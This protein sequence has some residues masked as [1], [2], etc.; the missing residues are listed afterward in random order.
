[1]CAVCSPNF[2][3]GCRKMYNVVFTPFLRLGVIGCLN[4]KSISVSIQAL[5]GAKK[6]VVVP[7]HNLTFFTRYYIF[8]A[9]TFFN[10]LRENL[11]AIQIRAQFMRQFWEFIHQLENA[12]YFFILFYRF[13]NSL[14]QLKLYLLLNMYFTKELL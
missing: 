2:S 3:E 1:M 10:Y 11:K 14:P 4:K 8:L 5:K 13:R 6:K 12:D 7:K 9:P